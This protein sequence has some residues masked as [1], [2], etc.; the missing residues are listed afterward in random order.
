MA[1][2][3]KALSVLG[4]DDPM[5]RDRI[6]SA[7][8]SSIRTHPDLL[9]DLVRDLIAWRRWELADQIREIRKAVGKDDPLGAY[10]VVMYLRQASARTMEPDVGASPLQ[11]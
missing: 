9:P 3:V 6:V 2:V 8:A 4:A 11:R 10:A 7:Y 5:L 1:E